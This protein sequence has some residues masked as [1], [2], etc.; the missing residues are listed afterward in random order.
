MTP[1]V[2]VLLAAKQ[3][4]T[5][6]TAKQRQVT[7]P[8]MTNSQHVVS[9]QSVITLTAKDQIHTTR[10]VSLLV[11]KPF[12]E[13]G[14]LRKVN[15]VIV[16]IHSPAWKKEIVAILLVSQ[17]SVDWRLVQPV[18]WVKVWCMNYSEAV[19]CN[20]FLAAA[21]FFIVTFIE[22]SIWSLCS[23]EIDDW[24]ESIVMQLHRSVV[25]L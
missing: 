17:T 15:S 11:M 12:V 22:N 14:R 21:K 2:L 13:T 18:V 25:V 3:V 23:C 7:V 6:C 10:D 16:G 8:I 24:L 9:H 19:H 4:T 5:S 1:M 20:I